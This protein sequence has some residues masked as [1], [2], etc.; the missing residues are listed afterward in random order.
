MSIELSSYRLGDLVLLQLKEEE[1]DEI[2]RDHPD[3]IASEYILETRKIKNKLNM[4][5]K[6][7]LITKIALKHSE[8]YKDLYP[9]DIKNS[10]LLHL[11]LGDVVSGTHYS[12]KSKRPLSI[13]YL[14]KIAPKN[15]KL[16]IIGKPFF[17]KPSST[18]YEECII[19]SQK[20]LENALTT[21]NGTHFIGN[22]ADIDL[23]CAL[24]SKYFIQGKGY[25]SKLIVEIRKKL[26]L[27][28]VETNVH[29]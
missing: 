7:D 27:F 10:V 9:E 5:Q 24:K 3:S 4:N 2:L 21:L 8:K 22:N 23:C 25:F 12:E 13:D 16:Y 19:N 18:N 1:K 17:A 15:M 29:S 28:N 20:Y 26:K 6:I 14:K 11:R